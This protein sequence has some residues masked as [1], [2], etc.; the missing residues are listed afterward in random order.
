MTEFVLVHDGIELESR[1]RLNR[2]GIKTYWRQHPLFGSSIFSL[3]PWRDS[4][5]KRAIIVDGSNPESYL[6]EL[7]VIRFV[8]EQGG[9]DVLNFREPAR[10][11]AAYGPDTDLVVAYYHINKNSTGIGTIEEMMEKAKRS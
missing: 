4:V 1:E 8:L 10:A 11:L 3:F 6:R 2:R 7:I 5:Y 9:C